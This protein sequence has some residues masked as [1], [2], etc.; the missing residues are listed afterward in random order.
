MWKHYER[1]NSL[2]QQISSL[3]SLSADENTK[4]TIIGTCFKETQLMTMM[5]TRGAQIN[6]QCQGNVLG[7][8]TVL[9][10]VGDGLT[11]K[12]FFFASLMSIGLQ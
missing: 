6:Q 7:I 12:V 4:R 9:K 3:L 2:E 5:L 10:H 11:S 8:S 1:L